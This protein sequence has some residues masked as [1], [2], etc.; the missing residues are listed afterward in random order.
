MRVVSRKK[1]FRR[2]VGVEGNPRL[3]ERHAIN[4]TATRRDNVTRCLA[5]RLSTLHCRVPSVFVT[6]RELS[7]FNVGRP[8]VR[9][10][11]LFRRLAELGHVEV[12]RVNLRVVTVC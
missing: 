3:D 2:G 6:E 10:F 7:A 1:F 12:R 8:L 4:Y 11:G 9:R 5:I